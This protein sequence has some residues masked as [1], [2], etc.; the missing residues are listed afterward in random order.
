MRERI[1][2]RFTIL[3][4]SHVYTAFPISILYRPFERFYTAYTKI[5]DG[6]SKTRRSVGCQIIVTDL[7]GSFFFSLAFQ[8]VCLFFKELKESLS[9]ARHLSIGILIVWDKGTI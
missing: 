8:I 6:R 1:I 5:H 9:E 3:N 4:I 2:G 7:R